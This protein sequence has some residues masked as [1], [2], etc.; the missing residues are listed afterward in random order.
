MHAM[1]GNEWRSKKKEGEKSARDEEARL[2][3]GERGGDEERAER[4]GAYA[5]V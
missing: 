4:T 2:G 3:W 5:W 1:G